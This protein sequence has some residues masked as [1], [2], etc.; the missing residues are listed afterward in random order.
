MGAEAEVTV[1][2]V[3]GTAGALVGAI[4]GAGV[5]ATV[6]AG[7]NIG[8]GVITCN[9]DGFQKHQ[10][11]IEDG[12]FIGSDAQLVAPVRIGKGALVAAGATITR[13]VPPDALALTRVPQE[14]KEGVAGRRRKMKAKK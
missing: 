9:Y 14:N 3:V 11:F 10:T 1:G 13:D 4:V 7:V 8:A 6:G 5:G 12:V 2:A